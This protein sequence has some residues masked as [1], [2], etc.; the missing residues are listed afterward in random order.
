MV[1]SVIRPM[2]RCLTPR[3][4]IPVRPT[5]SY[6]VNCLPLMI[7]SSVG[8]PMDVTRT[9]VHYATFLVAWCLA[10]FRI[11]LA[12]ARSGASPQDWAAIHWYGLLML[13]CQLAPP[14]CPIDL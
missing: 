4:Q 2:F 13:I 7:S 1:K 10:W 5:P 14:I 9:K 3:S 8:S 12:P 6:S 11:R